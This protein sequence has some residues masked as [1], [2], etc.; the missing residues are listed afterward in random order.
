M[1]ALSS[2]ESPQPVFNGDTMSRD[3]DRERGLEELCAELGPTCSAGAPECP[4]DEEIWNIK[5]MIKLT[6]EHLEAL[7]DKFGGEHNPPSIYL[8]AYE[9][10]TSKLDSLQQREQQLLEAMGNSTDF[11]PSTPALLD[12]KVGSCGDSSGAQAFLSAPNTLAVLSSPAD[13][14]RA[15][16]RSPQ[17]PIVRVFLPNKQ[18]TVVCLL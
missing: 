1:A 11:P 15:N 8:E 10:Y 12:V 6:Q 2:A 17:K 3:P 9:E 16:P 14:V 4:Q 18:R 7:L 13:A 5:Q